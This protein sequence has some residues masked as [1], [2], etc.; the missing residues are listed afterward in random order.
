MPGRITPCSA[1]SWACSCAAEIASMFCRNRPIAAALSCPRRS[2]K[3][4]IWAASTSFRARDSPRSRRIMSWSKRKRRWLHATH[5]DSQ[6]PSAR[7]PMRAPDIASAL[8][9]FAAANAAAH[10]PCPVDKQAPVAAHM[11]TYMCTHLCAFQLHAERGHIGNLNT[12][13]A[14]RLGALL[15]QPQMELVQSL[16]KQ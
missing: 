1:A 15:R 8:H 11:Y 3:R 14:G 2:D 7:R 6:Q 12:R 9:P 16:C 4:A 5:D 10:R 13:R